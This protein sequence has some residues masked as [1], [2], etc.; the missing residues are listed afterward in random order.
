MTYEQYYH[1]E[2]NFK[3]NPVPT[4]TYKPEKPKLLSEAEIKAR[5]VMNLQKSSYPKTM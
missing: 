4:T 2:T 3:A 1:W 5:A